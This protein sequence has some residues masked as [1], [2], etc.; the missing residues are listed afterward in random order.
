MKGEDE[1]MKKKYL[2]FMMSI[3]ILCFCSLH[4][5]GAKAETTTTAEEE[6]ITYPLNV[7]VERNYDYAKEVLAIVNEE[8]E[9]EGLS[10]VSLDYDITEAA[11][12]RAAELAYNYSHSRP[13]HT[14]LVKVANSI[15]L[16]NIALM[17]TSPTQVMKD[18]MNS[19]GHRNN[20]LNQ[21][22]TSVG[23]GC[24]EYNNIYCWVQLFSRKSASGSVEDGLSTVKE[25]IDVSTYYLNLTADAFPTKLAVGKS[26]QFV[27]SQPN[28]GW[29]PM[30]FYPDADSFDYASSDE[31]TATVDSNGVVY[32]K[33]TGTVTISAYYANTDTIAYSTT[34]TCVSSSDKESSDTEP[35]DSN[36][37]NKPDDTDN[38]YELTDEK[39]P[40]N[41]CCST[42]LE[43]YY[44][45]YTGKA[46]KPKVLVYNGTKF[47]TQGKDFTVSYK[48]NKN[49]GTGRIIITGKGKYCGTITARFTIDPAKYKVTFYKKNG[50]N[51][52]VRYVKMNT[53]VKAIKNPKKKGYVFKGWYTKNGKKYKFSSKVTRNITLY[54]KWKRK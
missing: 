6:E 31:N 52:V 46:I 54:A 27:L 43:R 41:S 38:N 24:V 49:P 19:E 11:M 4:S 26:T 8:R 34:I 18:W 9:E 7:T 28:C 5:I 25:S 48:D 32:A 30:I 23:I 15:V 35:T 2:F 39:I 16:E 53:A 36:V 45:S 47:L 10:S 33:S 44:F 21:N 17:E 3:V 20:I 42:I 50:K 12:L 1:K 51:K 22:W 13:N 29:E 40:L 14:G 37:A